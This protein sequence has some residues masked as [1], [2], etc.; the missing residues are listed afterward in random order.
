M[1]YISLN[2]LFHNQTELTGDIFVMCRNVYTS[3]KA[4]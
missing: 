3:M 4:L 1:I 2:Y